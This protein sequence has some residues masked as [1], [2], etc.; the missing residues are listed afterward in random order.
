MR[1][2]RDRFD[3]NVET[4]MLVIRDDADDLSRN[5]VV[6]H[7]NCEPLT[8]RILALKIFLHERLVD[9]YDVP[10]LGRFLFVVETAK[11]QRNLHRLEVVNVGDA[12]AGFQLPVR[13]QFLTIDLDGRAAVQA[14]ERWRIDRARS[15]DARNRLHLFDGALKEVDGFLVALVFSLKQ[16]DA[17]GQQIV[18]VETGIDSL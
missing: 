1:P 16:A 7:I 13:R 9:D 8:E 11:L 2:V 12:D 14:R 4:Q 18:W 10:H 5:I 3:R 17:Y 6:L 15:L